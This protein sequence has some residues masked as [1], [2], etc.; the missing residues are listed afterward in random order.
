MVSVLMFVTF[1]LSGQSVIA[2]TEGS[3][4][5]IRGGSTIDGV[6]GLSL[7]KSD[8]VRTG[9]DSL[10]VLELE[11]RGT[12]KLRSDTLLSLD[13]LGDSMS[14][15]LEKGGL[16]SKIRRLA[17][18]RSYEVQT[19]NVAAAVR[20]T[21]FFM[22]FGETVEQAPDLWLCVNEGAVE[23]SLQDSGESVL[24]K[25]GEGV[26]VLAGNRI[27]DPRFYS[28]TRNLNWNVDPSAGELRDDTDLSAAYTDLR[29]FDYD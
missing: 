7:V 27:T 3:V 15:S 9:P 28:W 20:G 24:V 22:A 19:P 8:S 12:V 21:E 4:S 18:A 1:V 11:N 29:D 2:Y 16:F 17:G 26:N 13:E 10:A 6:I 25:E 5:V 23:V 14:V